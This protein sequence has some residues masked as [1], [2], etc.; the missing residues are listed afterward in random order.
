MGCKSTTKHHTL[1]H[2][3][4]AEDRDG[5]TPTVIGNS[6]L[7]KTEDKVLFPAFPVIV[8]CPATRKEMKTWAGIDSYS[9]ASLCEEDV[10]QEL[11]IEPDEKPVELKTLNGVSAVKEKELSE[12]LL[13]LAEFDQAGIGTKYHFTKPTSA[14]DVKAK[15]ILDSGTYLCDGHLYIPIP[16]GDSAKEIPNN[17][18]YALK[19]LMG[20]K[21]KF[22]RGKFVK[23]N[24]TEYEAYRDLF[25]KYREKGYIRRIPRDEIEADEPVNYVPFHHVYHPAKPGKLRI[26]W[27]A[28]ARY[29]DTCLNDHIYT[30][31]DNMNSLLGVLLRFRTGGEI[32]FQADVNAMFNQIFITRQHWN[33]MRFLW[34]KDD[35][36]DAEPEE[37]QI[38]HNFFGGTHAPALAGYAVKKTCIDN[39]DDFHP[40]TIKT[41]LRNSYV[42]DI[43][44]SL[45]PELAVIV[46]SEIFKLYGK[47]GFE[48]AKFVTTERS[49]LELVKPELQ[50]PSM[51]ESSDL[52]MGCEHEERVLDVKWN[53]TDDTFG[54]KTREKERPLRRRGLLGNIAAMFDPEGSV[55]PVT[56]IPRQILQDITTKGYG[57]DEPLPEL[58]ATQVQKWLQSIQKLA[59]FKRERAVVPK[60]FGKIVSREL[61]AF[62]DGSETGVGFEIFIKSTNEEGACHISFL[63]AKALVTPTKVKT[64]PRIELQAM[65]LSM[66]GV[67]FVIK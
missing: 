13:R 40:E 29:G 41:G 1:L 51:K 35:D 23:E 59:D 4:K 66:R 18:G 42:D 7:G 30:G 5:T 12:Q 65:L 57:W 17:R 52:E 24:F 2:F 47:T 38:L 20:V 46:V 64:I 53:V 60:G 11:S 32:A 49:L 21:A 44:K 50:A 16:L 34:F 19:R 31:E 28:A 43:L 63:L 22:K 36:L 26:V 10:L 67:K 58:E 61:H 55:A 45:G 6:F 56:L 37:Y 14:E 3:D 15:E 62:S 39:R 8:R 33:L 9:S 54:F 48:L 27:D 25:Q